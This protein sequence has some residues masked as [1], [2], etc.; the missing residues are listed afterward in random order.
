V[1]RIQAFFKNFSYPV[2]SHDTFTLLKERRGDERRSAAIGSGI[3][4]G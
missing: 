1:L 3:R 4:L 2:G